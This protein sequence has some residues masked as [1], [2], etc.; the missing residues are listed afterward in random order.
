MIPSEMGAAPYQNWNE[1]IHAECY[2]PNA[3]LGNF[4]RISFNIGPTLFSWM[5]RCDEETCRLIIAQD[6]ANVQRYGV[7][8]AMSQAYNHTILPLASRED[9]ITQ[10][11]WGIADFE[12]RFGR[13]PQG[14]WLPETGVDLETLAVLADQGIEYTILA[15]WQSNPDSIDPTEPYRVILPGG[16]RIIAFFYNRELSAGVSFNASLTTNADTFAQNALPGCFNPEKTQRN[17]PQL[18]MLASDGELYGHHQQF[19]DRFLA[20]LVNGASKQAGLVCTYPGL[21]L[22]N[23]SVRR[24]TGINERTSWSCYHGVLRWMGE[25]ACT[26]GDGRW[27]AYLRRS[28][29][30]LAA[31]IDTLYVETLAPMGLD[32]WSLRNQY[33]HVM[34]GQVKLA[35][36]LHQV[37]KRHLPQD[38][39][40]RVRL[41]LEAQRERQRMFTSCGWYFEDFSRIEPRNNVAYA[42]QAVYLTRLATGVD[43]SYPLMGDLRRV[44][45]HRSGLR[46]DLVYQRKLQDASGGLD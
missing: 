28:L 26:P 29:N 39:L 32:P 20:H 36:L 43:L 13:K 40:E 18:V 42:A 16:K 9:K 11:V 25:C 21:W 17:E 22:K 46:A 6:R 24:S 12:A 38:D 34:L 5:A 14:M 27:K 45:S 31:A 7:G 33:I 2:R 3:E 4:E 8:N 23:H 41:L 30:N 19:R 1:R 44:V 10:V 15:P 37:A 35:E